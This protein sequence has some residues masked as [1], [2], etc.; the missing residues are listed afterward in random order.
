MLTVPVVLVEEHTEHY[1][2]SD[3][4]DSA[5]TMYGGWGG[6]GNIFKTAAV[7]KPNKTRTV[8]T[9]SDILIFVDRKNKIDMRCLDV[10]FSGNPHKFAVTKGKETFVCYITEDSLRKLVDEP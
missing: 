7:T 8:E 1:Y 9:K 10:G 6:M 5:M 3:P 2:E 4:D